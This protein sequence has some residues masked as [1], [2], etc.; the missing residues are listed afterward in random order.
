MLEVLEDLEEEI[1]DAL[2]K[3]EEGGGSASAVRRVKAML[4][5]DFGKAIDLIIGKITNALK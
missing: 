4:D 1:A 2:S 5:Q 3:F